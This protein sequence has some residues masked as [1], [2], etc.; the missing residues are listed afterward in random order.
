MLTMLRQGHVLCTLNKLPIS[1]LTT[2]PHLLHAK[3]FILLPPGARPSTSTEPLLPAPLERKRLIVRR[4][5]VAVKCPDWA[6]AQAY[7]DQV[8]QKREDEAR[9]VRENRAARGEAAAD[10]EVREGGELEEAIE[11]FQADE[12]WEREQRNLK[13]KGKGVFAP[14]STESAGVRKGAR[15]F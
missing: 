3:P 14:P 10:V 9:F 4:F 13:G 15:W 12:R 5:Q 2:T 1:T 11:A 8:F 7:C 6:V